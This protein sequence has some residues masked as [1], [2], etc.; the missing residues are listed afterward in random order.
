MVQPSGS[1]MAASGKTDFF[2]LLM[3]LLIDRIKQ[4]WP[5]W[6]SLLFCFRGGERLL[7]MQH[8][9]DKPYIV[10]PFCEFRSRWGINYIIWREFD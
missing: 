2:Q 5:M 7:K 4:G 10:A 1:R 8:V 6:L 9:S 3:R